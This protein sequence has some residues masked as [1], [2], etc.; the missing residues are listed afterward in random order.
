MKFFIKKTYIY[1]C[2]FYSFIF[3]LIEEKFLKY[4]KKNKS[5][6]DKEGYLKIDKSSNLDLANKKLDFIFHERN[7]IIYKDYQNLIVLN[8]EKLDLLINI[9]FEQQ[10]CSFLTSLTGYKY[11]ID[12]ICVYQNFHIPEEKRE[13]AYYASHYHLDKPNSKNMLKLFIPIEYIGLDDG[14]LEILNIGETKRY[15]ANKKFID[16]S[17][18][19]FFIGGP[20]DFYLC[21][22]NL[23]LHR[24]GIPKKGKTTKLIMIQ[25]NPS[26]RWYINSRIYKRQSEIEPKFNS[27]INNFLIRKRLKFGN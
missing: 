9:L 14:P 17:K 21:K 24:A 2:R 13:K 10:F 20:G 7:K 5:L 6:L 4:N 12:F 16:D 19:I 23:C 8:K 27:F 15:L 22:L 11:S 26:N 25:L 1:F 18:K 3:T